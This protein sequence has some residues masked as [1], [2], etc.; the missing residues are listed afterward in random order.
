MAKLHMSRKHFIDIPGSKW[1]IDSRCKANRTLSAQVMPL[2][3]GTQGK[4]RWEIRTV[5]SGQ[6]KMH[7]P[8]SDCHCF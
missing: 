4:H 3:I 5:V 6:R 2:D 7:Q 8:T 1:H